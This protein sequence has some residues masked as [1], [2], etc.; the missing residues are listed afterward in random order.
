MVQALVIVIIA[1]CV[2]ALAYRYYGIFLA[3]KVL[4]LDKTRKTPAERLDDGHDYHPTNKYVL[5]GHHFAA[6]AGAGP[7]IGPVLAAQFGYLPGLLWILIGA[8]LAGAVHDM[9]I[10]FASVRYQGRSLSVI[11]QDLLGKRAGIV[12]SLSVLF[13]LI[14]ALSGI[15]LVV[16]KALAMSSD[17]TMTVLATIPIALFMGLYMHRLRPGDIGGASAIG[18]TLLLLTI[19][20]GPFVESNP[21]LSSIFSFNEDFFKVMIPAYGII[22]ASLPV[23]LLLCPRDYLSSFLKVGVVVLLALGVFIVNPELQMPA[24]TQ[25]FYGG[26]P[27]IPG[28]AIPYL[29]ITIACGALSGFHSIIGTGTTPKMLSNEVDIRFIGYGAMLTEAFVAIMALIAA[30]ALVPADY[31]AINVAPTIYATLGMT[32]IQ[33]PMLEQIIGEKLA[34]RTGGGVSLAVGMAV[35]FDKIPLVDGLLRYWYHFAIMMEAVFVLTAVDTGTRVGR[36]LTQD[37]IGRVIPRFSEKSWIPGIVISSILFTLMWGYLLYTGNISTIWPIFGM[38]NQLLA[39]TG[40]II[41]TTLLIRMGK[42]RYMWV[43]ALPGLFMLPIVFDA[44]YLNILNYL[45]MQTFTGYLLVAISAILMVLMALV[46]IEAVLKWYELLKIPDE[47]PGN[48]GLSM[49]F[50]GQ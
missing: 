13:I 33:L 3:T 8:V 1:L 27:I 9:I 30:C 46:V 22:A 29:F 38:S 24:L 7:L 34:G 49:G 28:P 17:N 23:W 12:V 14:L 26:G 11:T 2:F 20:A 10:L 16:V 44:G 40:L 4:V 41:G 18:L 47:K 45:K 21:L 35:I 19:I 36:Y 37:L 39:A 5:F 50:I 25:Y 6:I 42:R 43:T 48:P 32:P 31:F 15:S